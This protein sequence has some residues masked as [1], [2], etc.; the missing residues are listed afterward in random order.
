MV[1]ACSKA[2]GFVEGVLC[3]CVWGRC[4]GTATT[5]AGKALSD[6]LLQ[7]V[8]AGCDVALQLDED[9]QQVRTC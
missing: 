5:T 6:D 2:A 9:K 4:I 3:W 1:A 8:E 7:K